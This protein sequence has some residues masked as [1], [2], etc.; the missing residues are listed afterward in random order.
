MFQKITLDQLN[1]E[2]E[3][4]DDTIDLI[5]AGDHLKDYGLQQ[6]KQDEFVTDEK[7]H[8]IKHLLEGCILVPILY[9]KKG[10]YLGI[11]TDAVKGIV[12][13]GYRH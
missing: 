10:G 6:N 12:G 13:H 9:L 2:H 5:S 1:H 11:N 7:P 8:T 4:Q 3:S